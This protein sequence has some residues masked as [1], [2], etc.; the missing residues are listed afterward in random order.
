MAFSKSRR[1]VARGVETKKI[2]R[3][4][5]GTDPK[6][7]GICSSLLENSA[8]ELL[9]WGEKKGLLRFPEGAEIKRQHRPRG[10][11]ID[12][13]KDQKIHLDQGFGLLQ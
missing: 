1:A 2:L 7:K 3:G 5:D 8:A 10:G 6:N 13:R 4:G 9:K 12:P 11:E